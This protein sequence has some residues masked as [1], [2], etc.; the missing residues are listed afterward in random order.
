LNG[1]YDKTCLHYACD[2]SR[3][4]DAVEFLL[5]QGVDPNRLTKAVT[6]HNQFVPSISPLYLVLRKNFR[7]KLSN[8][9]LSHSADINLKMGTVT[10]LMRHLYKWGNQRE[11]ELKFLI[12]HGADIDIF[13]DN[14]GYTSRQYLKGLGFQDYVDYYDHNVV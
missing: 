14:N 11:P 10:A 5:L 4:D 1:Y 2:N 3:H 9:L 12:K 8:L 7:S 13:D 6:I